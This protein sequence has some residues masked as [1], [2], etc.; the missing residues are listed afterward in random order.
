M[1]KEAQEVLDRVVHHWM[2]ENKDEITK[3]WMH[4]LRTGKHCTLMDED[5]RIVAVPPSEIWLGEDT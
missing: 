4:F 1:S 5:G 2:E 3:A